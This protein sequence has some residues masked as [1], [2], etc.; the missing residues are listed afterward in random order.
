LTAPFSFERILQSQPREL[1]M[2][3]F[4][5]AHFQY[6]ENYG[7]HDWDGV[8]SC[9]QHWKAK[10]GHEVELTS[11]KDFSTFPENSEYCRYDLLEVKSYDMGAQLGA[12]LHTLQ[13][14]ACSEELEYYQ[15]CA[16]S[17]IIFK[18]CIDILVSQGKISLTKIDYY[19][20]Q[21]RLL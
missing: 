7:A 16:E 11:P 21:W 1:V 15:H 20:T 17:E 5:I 4:H 2:T 18:K 12:V 14:E 10:G 8:G 13:S 3:T 6:W 19:S 9:P